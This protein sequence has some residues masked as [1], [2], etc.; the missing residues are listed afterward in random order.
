MDWNQNWFALGTF[1]WAYVLSSYVFI[2]VMIQTTRKTNKYNLLFCHM[3][4]GKFHRNYI[5]RTNGEKKLIQNGK[6]TRHKAKR[7]YDERLR[8]ANFSLWPYRHTHFEKHKPILFSKRKNLWISNFHSN[9]TEMIFW[10]RH[11]KIKHS[12]VFHLKP[13]EKVLQHDWSTFLQ[14]S[15]N[16]N[17]L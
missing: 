9:F 3:C 2:L 16:Q 7:M 8:N 15:L 12:D 10:S 5:V 11:T 4:H 6:K 14:F 17:P 13:F 1:Y